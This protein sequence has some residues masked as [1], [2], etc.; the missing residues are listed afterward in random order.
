MEVPSLFTI[1][2]A[3]TYEVYCPIPGPREAVMTGTLAV[4]E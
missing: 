4:L 1:A 2:E 3:E